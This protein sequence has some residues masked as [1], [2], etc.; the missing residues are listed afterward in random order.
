VAA[1]APDR[2]R[3]LNRRA[4]DR[5]IVS[6]EPTPSFNPGPPAFVVLDAAPT[7]SRVRD[8]PAL[9]LSGRNP[10]PNARSATE[11]PLQKS[12]TLARE[13]RR[14]AH[15]RDAIRF[16]LEASHVNRRERHIRLTYVDNDAADCRVP[17]SSG[18]PEAENLGDDVEQTVLSRV[19]TRT[20]GTGECPVPLPA[21]ARGIRSDPVAIPRCR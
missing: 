19:V 5:R 20:C 11:S 6:I 18:T 17:K 16:R 15:A 2:G 4:L 1:A 10:G 8:H 21:S 7:H 9:D 12:Q 13:H 14:R 3:L